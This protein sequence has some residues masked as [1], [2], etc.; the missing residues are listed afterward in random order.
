MG[1]ENLDIDKARFF[2]SVADGFASFS[3][4][5]RSKVGIVAV[6]DNRIILCG[7]NGTAPGEDNN[8]EH[9]L[10]DG[11]LETKESVIH[12]EG[13][14]V[15]Y[16]TE[17]GISLKGCITFITLSPCEPCAEKLT[18]AGISGLIYKDLYRK[19]EG[20]HLLNNNNIPT[21]KLEL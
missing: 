13:N 1:F 8:C 10:E 2:M 6:R 20:L 21:M 3:K 12:A 9:E 15:K 5:R 16:A 19:P 14:M 7:Y 17:H 11:T 4:A 18:N